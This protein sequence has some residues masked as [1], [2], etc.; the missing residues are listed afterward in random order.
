MG[1][2][3]LTP[4]PEDDDEDLAAMFADTDEDTDEGSEAPAPGPRPWEADETPA[5]P[6]EETEE[7]ES[8]E[9]ESEDEEEEHLWAGTFRAPE[10]LENA[11]GE[12]RSA[13]TRVTQENAQ[14]RGEIQHQQAQV[15]ETQNQIAQIVQFLQADMAERDPDFAEE[16]GRRLEIDNAVQ[17]R[18]QPIQ[19][20]MEAQQVAQR[21]AQFDQAVQRSAAAFYAKHTEITPGSPDDVMLTQTVMDLVT[22]GVPVDITNPEHLEIGIAAMSNPQL[23]A[24]LKAS[25]GQLNTANIL[26]FVARL[27][28]NGSATIQPAQEPPPSGQAPKGPARRRMEGFVETR[29]GGAPMDGAPGEQ[30]RDEFDEAWDYWQQAKDKGP[31]FGAKS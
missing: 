22:A 25:A 21:Q 5:E 15:A 18:V 11:Y 23:A 13:F 31:L 7:P 2:R 6:E 30:P 8:S 19:Q 10:E 3:H 14:L 28:P 12:V 26:P 27:A 16:L 29:S 1:I 24:Q 20:Q 9:E 17:Q 4:E